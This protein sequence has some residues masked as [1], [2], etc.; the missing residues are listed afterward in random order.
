MTCGGKGDDCAR[1]R[2]KNFA[3][4]YWHSC[5][6]IG[7]KKVCHEQRVHLYP[8]KR[9]ALDSEVYFADTPAASAA[10]MARMICSWPNPSGVAVLG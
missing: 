7:L 2:S 8:R 6:N 1:K 3:E 4:F 5:I 10:Q 9:G